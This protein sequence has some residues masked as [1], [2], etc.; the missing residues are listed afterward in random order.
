MIYFDRK[1]LSILAYIQKKHDRG[2]SWKE[3]QGKFGEDCANPYL[4]ESFTVELYTATKDADGKWLTFDEKW[5]GVAR[6]EMRS[7]CT[8]KGNE[9]LERRQFDFWKWIIPTLISVAALIVSFIGLL[10]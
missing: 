8:P 9:L 3:L 4:L 5:D 1:T 6:G 2:A 7:Y 10:W